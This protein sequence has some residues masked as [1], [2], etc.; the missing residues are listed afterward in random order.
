MC[1]RVL[2]Y[3]LC[4]CSHFSSMLPPGDEALRQRSRGALFL[5]EVTDKAD[6]RMIA[7]M[8]TG[9]GGR[10]RHRRDGGDGGNLDSAALAGVPIFLRDLLVKLPP[11]KG[12]APNIDAYLDQLRRT[13]LPPRPVTDEDG[14]GVARGTGGAGLVPDDEGVVLAGAKRG[15]PDDDD[16]DDDDGGAAGSRDDIFRK[17]CRM[18]MTTD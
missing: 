11:H 18:R 3:L 5:K 15:M 16:D 8:D 12:P 14:T 9:V 7:L 2:T 4:R 10:R 1:R 6:Q 13:V 17:R